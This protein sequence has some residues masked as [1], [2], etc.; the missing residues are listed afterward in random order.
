ML[1]SGT[2]SSSFLQSASLGVVNHGNPD[3]ANSA[4]RE[5]DKKRKKDKYGYDYYDEP[6]YD[7]NGE[8]YYYGDYDKDKD[9]HRY[10][11]SQQALPHQYLATETHDRCS[12]ADCQPGRNK[13]LHAF[14]PW[15]DSILRL[16]AYIWS[17]G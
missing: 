7:G 14:S 4:K 1:L 8:Y 3:V 13:W 15:I 5:D 10:G 6:T 11:V 12:G 16:Y 9:G 2:N 17:N